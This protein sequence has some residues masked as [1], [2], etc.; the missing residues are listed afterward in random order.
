MQEEVYDYLREY[1]FTMEEVNGFQDKNEKMFF[2]NIHEITKN[3]NYLSNKGLNKEEIIKVLRYNPYML[4]V[5][6]NRL[7]ALDEIYLNKLKLNSEELKKLIITNPYTYIESPIELDRL[8]EY[9]KEN[10][11]TEETIKK[12]FIDNPKLL[13]M[14][15][16]KFIETVKFKTE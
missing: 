9:L 11:C 8:I 4:T 3:I 10:K 14:R 1:G 6:N 2:T 5:K 15:I 12:F 16:D 7:D 13:D